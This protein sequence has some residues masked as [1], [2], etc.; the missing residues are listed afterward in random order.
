MSNMA[1]FDAALFA[2]LFLG[3][4]AY[5]DWNDESVL[6]TS[7]NHVLDN[8]HRFL[9]DMNGDFLDACIDPVLVLHHRVLELQRGAHQ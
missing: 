9:A 4:H 6:F 3:L 7:F 1:L 5:L 2:R 8:R